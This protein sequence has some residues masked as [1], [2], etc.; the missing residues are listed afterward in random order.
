MGYDKMWNSKNVLVAV[1]L[2][3]CSPGIAQTV[4]D[5]VDLYR[6][7]AARLKTA[8]ALSVEVEKRFDVILTDGAKIEYSGA[9]DMVVTRSSGLFI[10]YGDDFGAKQLWYDGR[11]L[12]LLDTLKNVYASV[13]VT[14]SVRDVLS[15][16]NKDYDLDM[17][18]APLLRNDLVDNLEAHGK[19][20]YLGLHDVEGEP[21]HHLLFRGQ[22]SDMQVWI[23]DGDQPLLCKLV[24]TFWEIEGAPQQA[25]TFTEWDLDADIDEQTFTAKI[26]ESA[27]AIEFL[28]LGGE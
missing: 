4:P 11:T 26:P 7:A 2:V 12:T 28:S 21:C 23:R 16:V 8:T 6:A 24:V 18:L 3:S 5:P 15:Q 27:R 17:P 13:P 20:S 10:D 1:M 25:L 14:G 9:L 22:T 19:A